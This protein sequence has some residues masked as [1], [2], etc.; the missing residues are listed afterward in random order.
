MRP[1]RL[2][3]L[4]RRVIRVTMHQ[5]PETIRKKAAACRIETAW[6]DDCLD[7][8]EDIE[9][10]LL[11][12]FEGAS[13]ADPAPEHPGHLPR[14]RLFIDNLWDH[15]GGCL[16]TFRD[17]VRITLLHELGHYLGL[18]EDEISARGLA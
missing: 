7:L 4:A 12:L 11:G 16:D 10:D 9:D 1:E 14:I 3:L 18:D 15:S 13:L 17:E 6:I 2:E 5:L 8:G